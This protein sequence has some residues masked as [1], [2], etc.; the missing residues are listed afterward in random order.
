M[1][2]KYQLMNEASRA[3]K[4][5]LR[6]CE[7]IRAAYGQQRSKTNV[8]GRRANRHR[9]FALFLQSAKHRENSPPQKA[10]IPR[11]KERSSARARELHRSRANEQIRTRQ[12]TDRDDREK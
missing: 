4:S 2:N 7:E 10:R 8:R 9:P 3:L 6:G 12:K 1:G 11:G 5:E